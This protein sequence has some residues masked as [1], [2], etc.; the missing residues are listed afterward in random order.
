MRVLHIPAP[1]NAGDTFTKFRS[2]VDGDLAQH[3]WWCDDIAEVVASRP[4]SRW[5]IVDRRHFLGP[6]SIVDVPASELFFSRTLDGSPI[7]IPWRAQAA[8]PLP[9]PPAPLRKVC[10]IHSLGQCVSVAFESSKETLQQRHSGQGLQGG[11]MG[12]V[13]VFCNCPFHSLALRRPL[14]GKEY[15]NM[16]VFVCVCVCVGGSP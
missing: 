3:R 7:I 13:F 8:S 12:S 5:A 11:H 4:H 14:P 9:I 1:T 10:D 15:V 2:T 16:C 6:A